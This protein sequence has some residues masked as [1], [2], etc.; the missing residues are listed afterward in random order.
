M[1]GESRRRDLVPVALVLSK[2]IVNE[3]KN[4]AREKADQFLIILKLLDSDI[5]ETSTYIIQE[6]RI[7]DTGEFKEMLSIEV[8][9]A[10]AEFNRS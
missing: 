2:I 1:V 6:L 4:M 8:I 10:C 7:E 5:D 3:K 9:Q